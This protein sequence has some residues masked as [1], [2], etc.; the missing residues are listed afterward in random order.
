MILSDY[1]YDIGAGEFDGVAIE[2]LVNGLPIQQPH[3]YD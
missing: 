1:C 3:F 2:S